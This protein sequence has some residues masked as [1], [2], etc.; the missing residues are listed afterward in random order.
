MTLSITF[1]SIYYIGARVKKLSKTASQFLVRRIER[2]VI[3]FTKERDTRIE[4]DFRKTD[5]NLI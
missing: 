2:M 5:M 1:G 3:P 4:V